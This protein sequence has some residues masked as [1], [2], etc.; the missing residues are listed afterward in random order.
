MYFWEASPPRQWSWLETMWSVV[1]KT[2]TKM[3][4]GLNQMFYS[5]EILTNGNFSC[6]T[7]SLRALT[8]QP[9]DWT[10]NNV[11]ILNNIIKFHRIYLW[12]DTHNRQRCWIK[13][14]GLDRWLYSFNMFSLEWGL[15]DCSFISASKYSQRNHIC[16][17]NNFFNPTPQYNSLWRTY[18]IC[19]DFNE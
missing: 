6:C 16:P 5:K 8:I 12:Y 17:S 15:S 7:L 4:E 9:V 3:F 10:T 19:I 2:L 11:N 1:H 18:S 14:Y 13:K